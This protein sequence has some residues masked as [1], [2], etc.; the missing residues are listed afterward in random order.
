MLRLLR[1]SAL[2]GVLVA[3]SVTPPAQACQPYQ[4]ST[5]HLTAQTAVA[6][7]GGI[8]MV[9]TMSR[10]EGDDV[11][12]GMLVMMVNGKAVPH[13]AVYLGRGLTL[14]RG[15]FTKTTKL[16]IARGQQLKKVQA[17][18]IVEDTSVLA[19]PAVASAIGTVPRPQP[20][21]E[22][23][24]SLPPGSPMTSV[25]L[26]LSAALPADATALVVYAHSTSG[27]D[28]AMTWT[29][30]S[31]GQVDFELRGGGKGCGGGAPP[32]YI[33]D[34]LLFSYVTTTGRVSPQ[35][36]VR[37][38]TAQPPATPVKIK[39]NKPKKHN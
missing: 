33:G 25:S 27:Q 1:V 2:A 39:K 22:T 26:H 15:K 11:N 37:A 14:W 8:L 17:L 38:V 18:P 13:E 7:D 3:T 6:L 19:A 24:V 28:V 16:G 35:T 30:V 20:P 21:A 9:E 10:N 12:D 31:K 36:A 34:K 5:V 4:M 32:L 23:I 29:L